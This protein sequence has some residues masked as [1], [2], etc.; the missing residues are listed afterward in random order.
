MADQVLRPA[1]NYATFLQPNRYFARLMKVLKMLARVGAGQKDD[2]YADD[3]DGKTKKS[4]IQGG[5]PQEAGRVASLH[6]ERTRC[7]RDQADS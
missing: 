3:N 5:P 7:S 1:V 2:K 6:A 4:L